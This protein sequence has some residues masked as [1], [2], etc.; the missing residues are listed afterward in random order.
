[1][2]LR[3]LL[4]LLI[5]IMI[6]P[7][8]FFTVYSLRK[9]ENVSAS[10]VIMNFMC[11]L[12]MYLYA[13][14]LWVEEYKYV[15]GF[16]NFYYASVPWLLLSVVNFMFIFT[17]IAVKSKASIVIK[18]LILICCLFDLNGFIMNLNGKKTLDIIQ[19][20]D[21]TGELTGWVASYGWIFNIH[22][23]VSYI[24]VALIAG[25]LVRKIIISTKIFRIKYEIIFGMFLLIIAV[26]AVFLTLMPEYD[27]SILG[28]V[29]CAVYLCYSAL[30]SMPKYMSSQMMKLISENINHVV[31]CFDSAGNKVY[32]NKKA[33]ELYSDI[34]CESHLDELILETA[35]DSFMNSEILKVNG[36]EYFFDE[37]ITRV[38][39]SKNRLVGV[40]ANLSDNTK[41]MKQMQKELYDSTHDELTGL[42][43]RRSFFEY[44]SKILRN[45]RDTEFYIV[46]TNIKDFKM[47]NSC[48]G[49]EL[50]DEVLIAQSKKLLL[51]DYPD[52]IH[53]RI[54]SDNFAMLIPKNCFNQTKAV[55]NTGSL[56][57][58]FDN[59]H[60]EIK[61]YIGIYEVSDIY[62]NV[63][64]MYD[65]A[66]LAMRSI[67]GSY[68]RT[69]AFY[70]R[71]LMD[72]LYEEKNIIA[73]FDK[74]IK[75][76]DFQVRLTPLITCSTEKLCGAQTVVYWM[77]PVKGLLRE[78]TFEPLLDRTMMQHKLDLYVWD[79]AAQI[80]SGWQKKG[81]NLYLNIKV[82]QQSFYYTNLPEVFTGLV[83]KYDV[84]PEFMVLGVNENCFTRDVKMHVDVLNK[85]HD[86][87]FRIE[88]DDFGS[89]F[90]SLNILK[91]IDADILKINFDQFYQTEQTERT[92]T[93]IESMI[94]MAKSVGM[95]VTA[96]CMEFQRQKDFLRS[97]G[98][99]II[100][101][102]YYENVV[103]ES[104]FEQMYA[105]KNLI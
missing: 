90:S 22:L 92:L 18:V 2:L 17:G 16:A 87:G 89:Q 50:G 24:Q 55:E 68:D 3:Y 80:L 64:S 4:S 97:A 20:F 46:A 32:A 70:D 27:F 91:D 102:N 54:S 86:A 101:E 53:G 5:Y 36:R 56:Q 40:C 81:I 15:F 12:T 23:A 72:K 58:I 8:V 7:L 66:Q 35:S 34:G 103:S 82:S 21:S 63:S 44:A 84:N 78:N 99:D 1:M 11:L 60:Y 29:I 30:Y 45:S 19:K 9:K 48:F 25:L 31:V 104:E 71:S 26:N 83:K 94:T 79:K 14:S 105:E 13:S 57:K 10:L 47:I 43:N 52:T 38:K 49:T 65:K 85:L 98:C 88:L 67:Y 51:A 77:N 6:L 61:V 39:D 59:L 75:N 93:I 100:Q 33:V 96:R 41:V 95:I 37:E 73:D 42:Y 76:G 62:E 74:F 69:L 28:Y